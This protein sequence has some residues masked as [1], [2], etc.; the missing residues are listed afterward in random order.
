MEILKEVIEDKPPGKIY[1]TVYRDAEFVL[2]LT[3]W[4]DGNL[5]ISN[6]GTRV[7]ESNTPYPTPHEHTVVPYRFRFPFSAEAGEWTLTGEHHVIARSQRFAYDM[8]IVRNG[9]S[10]SGD[11]FQNESYYAYGQEIL[12]PAAGIVIQAKEGEPENIPHR[13]AIHQGENYVIL[14]VDEKLYLYVT[15]LKT[16]SVAVTP[17]DTIGEG[18]LLGRVGNSANSSEPHLH[19]EIFESMP[20]RAADAYPLFFTMSSITA[21]PKRKHSRNMATRWGPGA[22]LAPPSNQIF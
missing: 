4:F 21:L 16:G 5:Q 18:Q 8:R 12:S 15:H 2:K 6:V 19:I 10:W 13:D 3:L 7:D 20:R 1:A 22:P 14:K 17:G 9:A 11:E